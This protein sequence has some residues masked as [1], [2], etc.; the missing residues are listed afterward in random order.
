MESD[1]QRLLSQVE[2]LADLPPNHASEV[3]SLKTR[4]EL[5]KKLR[6][7]I[8]A[9]DDPGDIVDKVIYAVRSNY[10]IKIGHQTKNQVLMVAPL[11]R[12]CRRHS[13]RHQHWPFQ[14]P[15]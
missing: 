9:L 2:T 10:L 11:A 4:R 3:L 5:R 7:L 8:I 13:H 1:Y 12:R 6:K 15:R 14:N